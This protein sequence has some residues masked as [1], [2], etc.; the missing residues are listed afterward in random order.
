MVLDIV[1]LYIQLDP[2]FI[3]CDAMSR[4][5]P[6]ASLRTRLAG[7]AI[8]RLGLLRRAM[9]L[10]VRAVVI[11]AGGRVFLVRHTYV[12]GWYLPGG[13]VE[14]GEDAGDALAR[15]LKEEGRI[16]LTGAADLFGLYRNAGRDHVACYIV[17]DF[18]QEGAK[19]PDRE[20]AEAGFFAPAA[21]P[22]G[23]TR[24]TRARLAAILDGAPQSP[25]W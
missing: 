18:V 1:G 24:A 6:D 19:S 22:E 17:R 10:G 16:R 15:E 25:R 12:A 11:D 21:L 8:R 5:N 14:R 20:I 7:G 2:R 4:S 9:T 3:G 13:G 23:A